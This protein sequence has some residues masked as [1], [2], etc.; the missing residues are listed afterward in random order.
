MTPAALLTATVAAMTMVGT[1]AAIDR[2]TAQAAFG[3]TRAIVEFQRA[4]DAYA[5]THRQVELRLGLAHRRAG[6]PIDVIESTELA[7]ALIA[8][9]SKATEGMLFT[10]AVVSAFR[11]AAGRASRAPG[12]EPGELRT[13]VW[14]TSHG[15]NSSATGTKPVSQCIAAALPALPEELAYRS[16]GTVL[17]LVDTHANLIVDALPALLAGSEIRR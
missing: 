16:G 15:V 10:P 7:A 14:E 8:E 3:D 4:A 11:Q 9:R 2:V 6:K 13:G 5:F 12:C 1:A 17:L